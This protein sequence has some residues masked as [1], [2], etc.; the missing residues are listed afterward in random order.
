MEEDYDL[1]KDIPLDSLLI[2]PNADRTMKKASSV[3]YYF[4]SVT[5]VDREFGRILKELENQGLEKNTIV[6][7]TS[8]H[9]ETMCSQ[10]TNDPKNS[11]Y[12]ESMNVPFIVRYPQKIK[13][14]I[15]DE[16]LLSTP[17]IMPTLLG[18]SGLG[19]RIPSSVEG[20]NYA[21]WIVEQG[22]TTP[23]RNAALYIKNSDGEE[24]SEGK[25]ISYFPMERGIKT[26]D[27]TMSLKI[28]KDTK[29]LKDILLFNDS[30]D[31]YQMT[32]LLLSEN[33]E[34]VLSLCKKMVPLLKEAN[35]P[36]YREQILSDL[37][38]YE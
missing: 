4:A 35:D 19:K 1:Y 12:A 26:R 20:R 29:K 8:D 13:H 10:G 32:N 36:W 16:L 11:P 3:R 37:I 9:G 14:R 23:I 38:P 22:R 2:R 31:P 21:D 34:V 33:R 15:D 18:L 28:D 30:K 25:V 5:G 6:V 27:Y 7:F 17:D 24:D